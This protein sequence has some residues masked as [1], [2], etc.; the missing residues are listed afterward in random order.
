M[1]PRKIAEALANFTAIAI[2]TV[3]DMSTGPMQN[4]AVQVDAP[5]GVTAWTVL[6][7]GTVNGTKWDTVLTHTNASPGDGKIVWTTAPKP[8]K[9]VRL[10]CTAY[11]GTGT[12]V[13]GLLGTPG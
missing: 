3:I 9:K 1:S 5:V 7:E 6:L 8:V 12:L 4:F 11:T 2:G 13:A 10:N